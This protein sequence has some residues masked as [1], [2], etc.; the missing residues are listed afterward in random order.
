[1]AKKKSRL[2]IYKPFVMIEK[3]AS[4]LTVA[5]RIHINVS[6]FRE[7]LADSVLCLRKLFLFFATYFFYFFD[8][9]SVLF[10]GVPK[11]FH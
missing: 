1:M 7:I 11:K 3:M 8:F 9:F 4:L 2:Q 10:L 6:C 5:N